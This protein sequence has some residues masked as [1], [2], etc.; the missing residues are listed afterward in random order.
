MVSM[1]T[2]QVTLQDVNDNHPIFSR[3]TYN[4]VI[5]TRTQVGTTILTLSAVD[6]DLDSNGAVEYSLREA[7]NLFVV[8]LLS[9]EVTLISEISDAG[10]FQLVVMA[11]DQGNPRL[12]SNATV[13]IRVVPPVQVEFS[14]DG[15]GFLLA[16][17]STVQQPIGEHV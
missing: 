10:T 17:A 3:N 6:S 9:G 12:S 14:L 8:D 1:T 11:T 13:T 15:A 2:I 16:G 5:T 7:S 4:G